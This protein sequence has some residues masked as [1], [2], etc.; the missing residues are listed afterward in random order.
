MHGHAR[1]LTAS[2]RVVAR[3]L[4]FLNEIG[5][6]PG[7]DHLSAKKVIDHVQATGSRIVSFKSWCGGLPAPECA[8]NPL[9]YKF[10]WN[11]RGV[12]LAALNDARYRMNGETVQVSGNDL[13]SSVWTAPF[14]SPLS[15]E[16]IPNRDS[17]KY[18]NLYGLQRAETML[19]GTLRYAGFC[20]LMQEFRQLGLFDLGPLSEELKRRQS[21]AEA[22]QLL[23]AKSGHVPSNNLLQAMDWLGMT[24]SGESFETHATLLDSFCA[25]LQKKLQYSTGERDM[26]VMHHEFLIEGPQGREVLESSLIEYGQPEGF[27]AMA[28]TVGYPVAVAAEMI[29]DGQV[30]AFGV[31]APV[32]AQLYEPLLARLEKIAN[33][34]FKETRH[35]VPSAPSKCRI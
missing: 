8:D 9:A 1:G 31:I 34:R 29:A 15:L 32:T 14:R 35:V 33:I 18:S 21:W 6:D 23:L 2:S 17:L 27:S 22:I 19:R 3:R 7:L 13:L 16:G 10:S 4:T 30:A 20:G 28:R 11:P 24:S 25:L 5:L 26:V 12:L